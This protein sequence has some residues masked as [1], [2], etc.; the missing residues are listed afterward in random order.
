[1]LFIKTYKVIFIFSNYQF[2]MSLSKTRAT[3]SIKTNINKSDSWTNKHKHLKKT[4]YIVEVLKI[5]CTT[6]VKGIRLP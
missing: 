2:Y 1:M 4:K 3:T 5:R 6:D